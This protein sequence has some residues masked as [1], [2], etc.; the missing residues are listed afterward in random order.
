MKMQTAL[1]SLVIALAAGVAPALAQ[2]KMDD[3]NGMEMGGEKTMPA[4]KT[5]YKGIGVVKQVDVQAGSVTLAHG[6]V[7]SLNWPAMTMTYS[8]RDKP[9]LEKL[10]VGKKVEFEFVKE[11]KGFVVTGVK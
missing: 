4:A 7:K 1:V 6:P 10:A 3:M 8:V 11:G 2:Q 5:T 9:L